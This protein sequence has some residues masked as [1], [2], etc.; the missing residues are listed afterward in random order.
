M[1]QVVEHLPGKHKALSSKTPST[2]V[3][4][5]ERGRERRERERKGR[6][7]EGGRRKE[8]RKEERKKGRKAG[9]VRE[10]ERGH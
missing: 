10:K 6:K 3:K 8:G 1:A 2:T 7:E 4:E 9:T 5:R